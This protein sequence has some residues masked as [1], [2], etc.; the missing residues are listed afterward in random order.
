MNWS[1]YDPD[2]EKQY[3]KFVG[4]C[5][6]LMGI[7]TVGVFGSIIYLFIYDLIN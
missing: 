7:L 6:T 3:G 5:T 2:Y 1:D 4:V